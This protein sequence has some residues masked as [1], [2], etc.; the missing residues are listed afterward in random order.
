[1]ARKP[2]D[3][4]SP[5]RTKTDDSLR[6]E[7][8]NTDDA[9]RRRPRLRR[10]RTPTSVLDHARALADAACQ[11]RA[12]EGGPG[13]APAGRAREHGRRRRRDAPRRTAPSA[14]NAPPRTSPCAATARSRRTRWTPCWCTRGRPRTRTSSPSAP[15]PTTPSRTATTSWAW[16]PT[17]CATCSTASSSA[18]S[19]CGRRRATTSR[20]R[21]SR[22]PRT[23]SG[24]TSRG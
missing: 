4:R 12:Q 5:E 18:W 1:M 7:R 23:A 22:P 15:V 17:T 11:G 6:E 8:A 21:T 24:A 13:G 19:C 20:T 3:R 9:I 10:A 16:S 14:G 2:R